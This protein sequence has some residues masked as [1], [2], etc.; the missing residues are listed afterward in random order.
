MPGAISEEVTV[1]KGYFGSQYKDSESIRVGKAWPRVHSM[2]Q[3][4][5]AATCYMGL[6]RNQK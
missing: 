5:L 4:H 6:T 3:E 2:D 1:R